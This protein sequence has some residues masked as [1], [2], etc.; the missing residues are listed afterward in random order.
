MEQAALGEQEI[1]RWESDP[2]VEIEAV[3]IKPHGYEEGKRYPLVVQAHGG[4]TAHWANGFYADWHDWGQ[5]LAGRGFAVLMHNPRG[6][7]GYGSG[8]MNALHGEVGHVELRDLM[9]GVDVMIERGIADPQRLGI[10]GWSWGGYMTAWT[11]TQTDRFKAAVMG[12][13]LPNMVSDNSIGDIPG[14]NLSYFETSPYEDPDAL[15]ERSAIRHIRNCTTPVLILHGEADERVNFFQS[16]EMYVA[17]RE[18][19]KPHQFVTYPREPHGIR[20]RKHQIDLIERVGRWFEDR[21]S[22]AG[23]RD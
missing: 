6:S 18:L 23:D 20:E 7:T 17:L 22:G 15:W 8:F 4:P 16:V 2:G 19:D 21:L 12:A 1:V 13:G 9:S 14:A 10:G 3:L 11:V 5:Y